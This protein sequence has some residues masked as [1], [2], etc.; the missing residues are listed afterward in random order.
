[1]WLSEL[2]AVG[3]DG[4]GVG[5]V[6][7]DTAASGS[8]GTKASCAGAVSSVFCGISVV[9]SGVGI[10]GIVGLVCPSVAPSPCP[11]LLLVGLSLTTS[12]S[13]VVAVLPSVIDVEAVL[14]G[15]SGKEVSIIDCSESFDVD[16][17]SASVGVGEAS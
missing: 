6:V 15:V 7:S 4:S 9:G 13:G 14:V 2:L 11:A 12:K 8:K 1:M 10:S 17:L 5:R 3:F 16:G